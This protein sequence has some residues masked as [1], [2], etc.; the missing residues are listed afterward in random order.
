MRRFLPLLSV[1][2]SL[3]IPP[4]RRSS[5]NLKPGL[6]VTCIAFRVVVGITSKIRV[7]SFQPSVNLELGSYPDLWLATG[8]LRQTARRIDPTFVPAG[9]CVACIRF[10][11][12]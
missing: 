2:R 4:R 12:Q 7:C 5:Q 1:T 10:L 9:P 11:G 6:P 8:A 3:L